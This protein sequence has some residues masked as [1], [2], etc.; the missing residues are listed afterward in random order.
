MIRPRRRQSK[1]HPQI[2]PEVNYSY[3]EKEIYGG[4]RGDAKNV[5]GIEDAIPDKSMSVFK[6]L[7]SHLLGLVQRRNL[8]LDVTKAILK[9][10]LLGIAEMHD[11]DIVHLGDY[12]FP[13]PSVGV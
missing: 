11:R 8:S 5:R 1:G 6:Y 3:L 9:Q 7:R 12:S 13:L 10:G 4:L 2:P